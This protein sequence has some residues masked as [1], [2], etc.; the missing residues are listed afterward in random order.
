MIIIMKVGA[1][2]ENIDAVVKRVEAQG[3]RT[4][5]SA[6]EERTIIGLIGDKSVIVEDSM[7][8]MT[9]VER[10]MQ[11]S[12]PFK[13]AS[14]DFHP[15]KTIIDVR[16]HKIGG[17]QITVMAGPCSVEGME[18]FMEVAE[19]VREAGAH[20]LR[21]GAFKPRTSPYSFQGMGE[22]GLQ[23]M[24]EAREKT[25]LPI[26][27]EIMAPDQLSLIEQYADVLQIGTRNMQNYALLK[28]VGKS[29]LPVM[30]KRGFAS[31]IEELLMCAE[32][33]LA[34]G[35]PNV[36]LCERGIRTFETY[37]RNTLD[38]NA[39]PVLGELT[40]LPIIIDP[41][42][43]TGKWSL[44][45]SASLA[46]VAA[47]ADGLIIEVHQKPEEAMSDGAQSLKPA[48]FMELMSQMNRVAGAVNRSL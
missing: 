14:L 13:L 2:A 32:Y 35:N 9:G 1:T 4:H 30:L 23:I 26:I 10:M 47:G 17:D 15:E 16:G 34:H 18:P 42:H 5:L 33:I 37:T 25:G 45:H 19:S 41:S 21:G 40:H 48:R 36:M 7:L 6:G 29:T 24:A 20:I 31:T 39:V 46:A 11:V 12:R 8:Q 43:A 3:L 28:A 22:E 27:T 44:V 38:I